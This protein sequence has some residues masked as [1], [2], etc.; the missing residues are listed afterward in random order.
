MI[1]HK[2]FNFVFL[3]KNKL[4]YKKIK[5][6]ENFKYWF[7]NQQLLLQCK[8]FSFSQIQIKKIEIRS[9]NI[10]GFYSHIS[11]SYCQLI[12]IPKYFLFFDKG[13]IDF[14]IQ[15][16]LPRKLIFFGNFILMSLSGISQCV[17]RLHSNIYFTFNMSE[18]LVMNCK[19]K[20]KINCNNFYFLVK[21]K[22]FIS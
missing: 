5:K 15:C 12:V 22:I 6:F 19:I 20:Q 7:L 17:V 10:W 9:T 11:N 3:I 14:K 13:R 21:L 16:G 4:K 8:I 1:L 2:I 18:C